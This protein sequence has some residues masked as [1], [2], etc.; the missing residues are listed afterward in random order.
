GRAAMTVQ[1]KH[2]ERVY[3]ILSVSVPMEFI[4]D[5]EEQSLL[6]EVAG[7]LAFALYNMELEGERKL[8][9]EELAER[10]YDLGKRVKELTFLYNM[11]NLLETQGISA[12]E[13]YSGIVNMIPSAWQFPEITCA[14]IILGD[15]EFQTVNYVETDW[16][17]TEEI[18]A[19]DK[20][21]GTVEVC[22]REER[23]RSIGRPFFEEE[24]RLLKVIAERLGH[25]VERK[26]AEKT[27]VEN[28]ARYRALFD[29]SSDG[30]I[31]RDL[32]GNIMMA[33]ESV[34]R[35]T[36][37]PI[38]ELRAMNVKQFLSDSSIDRIAEKQKALL[39]D[40]EQTSIERYELRLIRKDGTERIG[41]A[42]TSLLGQDGQSPHVLAIIRDVT[43]QRQ[44]RDAMRAYTNQVTQAQE[45][46]R[47]RIARE[48]HDETIQDLASLGMDI[49]SIA[50]TE[51]E[52]SESIVE[53]LEG[54][55]TKTDSILN[56][57]RRF[58]QDL[59]PPMIDELGLTEALR[60]LVEDL[61]TNQS[62]NTSLEIKG[63]ARRFSPET[64]L[65]LFRITQE[66]L[67]NVKRHSKATEASLVVEF[68]TNRVNM[69]VV[70]N[71]HGFELAEGINAFAQAGKLGLIGMQERARLLGG[72]LRIESRMGRGTTIAI[73]LPV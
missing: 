19:G 64:E 31:V 67:N 46:E 62:I 42:V 8:V 58:S 22:C 72:S 20:R 71:G 73:E 55:R 25:I 3:G 13:I 1:L 53:G 29:F 7:D 45:E 38:H 15:Q 39:V 59:R 44:Q 11:S 17:Q 4:E 12:E 47:K 21:I 69:T 60:W 41:E 6:Q 54:L 9:G 30:I 61:G 35:L 70:D 28:E 14:K 32:E 37:Y 5:H 23:S 51:R 56:G 34:S 68:E 52:L 49:D 16:K 33:N 43:E 27:L 10:T 2:C 48:L 18:S 24:A 65:L 57:I 26:K 40:K 63:V 50:R 66:A 36:G